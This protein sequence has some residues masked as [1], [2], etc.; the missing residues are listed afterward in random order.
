[1]LA[2]PP[3]TKEIQ[4]PTRRDTPSRAHPRQSPRDLI[5][6]PGRRPSCAE[7]IDRGSRE[8]DPIF[9]QFPGHHSESTRQS[10][11]ETWPPGWCSRWL[12][13][14]LMLRVRRCAAL[15]GVRLPTLPPVAS[16]CRLRIQRSK[17]EAEDMNVAFAEHYSRGCFLFSEF[18]AVVSARTVCRAS[19]AGGKARSVGAPKPTTRPGG[20]PEAHWSGS[21]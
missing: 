17:S 19:T 1:M 14:L 20:F 11:C 18:L 8:L 12:S 16:V 5:R 9:R 4:R 3:A 6:S 7:G 2:R 21:Q 13:L 15:L 10:R